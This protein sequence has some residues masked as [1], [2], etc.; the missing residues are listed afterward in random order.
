MRRIGALAICAV[1]A[2][3]GAPRR[4]PSPTRTPGPTPTPPS[5]P[6]AAPNAG[7]ARARPSPDRD[8]VRRLAL[9]KNFTYGLPVASTVTPDGKS[10]LF[11]RSGPRDR[12][13]S[14]FELD[15]GT[16]A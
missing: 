8:F 13:Q 16:G 11:L 15:V 5:A 7:Q 3:G 6:T 2:C 1:V 12:R 14:L 4:D 9:T 10:V